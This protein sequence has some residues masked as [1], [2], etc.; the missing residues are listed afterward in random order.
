MILWTPQEVYYCKACYE[1]WD[2]KEEMLEAI[3]AQKEIDDEY[4][5]P[6]E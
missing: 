3:E 1:T 5:D 6:T 4:A 2:N